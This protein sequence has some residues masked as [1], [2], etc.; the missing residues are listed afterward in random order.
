MSNKLKEND[1]Y[2][3]I[4]HFLNN[5]GYEVK[6]EIKNCDIVAK[7]DDALIIIELKLTLNITL[8][9]QAVDRF[10]LAD[11]VYIAIP[12]QATIFKK[13]SKQVKK[14]IARLGLGLIVVD[15][16]KDLHYVEII[17]DPKDYQPRTNKRKQNALLKEFTERQGDT[18]KGGSTRKQ[19][20][21]TA[22]RQRC[23]RV[24][25]YLS[26][27]PCCRGAEIKKAIDEPQATLFLRDNYY[28]WFEKVDRGVYRL[29]QK[30]SEE[31][32]E[33]AIKMDKLALCENKKG[34][35]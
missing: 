12:K 15:I 21:F 34:D 13:Q 14:L 30:G 1:L 8:L 17:N 32:P 33:W 23:I 11:T 28:A 3:P 25:E 20:G 31:L 22:Y 27:L 18:Q 9:L 7:K 16:Q 35:S 2:L 29:S 24:A 10:S 6:G 26:A 4:K 5:L 19:A